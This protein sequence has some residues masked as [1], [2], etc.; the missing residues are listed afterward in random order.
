[1]HGGIDMLRRSISL[2]VP[3]AG[4]LRPWTPVRKTLMRS[5]RWMPAVLGSSPGRRAV[6]R[7]EQV[8]QLG[9]LDE[10]QR[11]RV[12]GRLGGV[13]VVLQPHRDDDLVHQRHAQARDLDEL[14][15][16]VEAAIGSLICVRDATSCSRSR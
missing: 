8:R 5:A 12:L 2:G 13:E 7:V 15:L 4:R 9:V 3:F 16:L 10:R 11:R 1:M 6:H 14:A